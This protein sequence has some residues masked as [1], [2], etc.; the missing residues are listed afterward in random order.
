M[1][2]ISEIVKLGASAWL[3]LPFAVIL[4]ALHALE[5]GHAKSLMAAYIVAIRGSARQ[6]TLLGISAAVGHTIVVWILAIF[7]LLLGNKLI[8]EQAEPWLWT[9]SGVLIII[10]AAR[11]LLSLRSHSHKHDHEHD[12]AHGPIAH[13]PRHVTTSDIIWFGFTGGLL[14][15]P[16][17]IAVLLV[18]I[19]IKAFAL[20]VAMVAAFSI[21]LAIT[22]VAIG[23]GA[24]WGA[25]KAAERWPWFEKMSKKAPY[26]SAGL[27]LIVGL[28][29][30]VTGVGSI[31]AANARK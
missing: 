29:M 20:G 19:H 25:N 27:M 26:A 1:P 21:G 17:A 31:T 15:C 2:D 30:L 24:A 13:A 4:G 12:H 23:I 7:G 10:L 5:P 16:S 11:I 8:V 3:Y 18:C 14:P 6:A 22:L 9:L 28:F